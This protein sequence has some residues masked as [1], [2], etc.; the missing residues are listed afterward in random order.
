MAQ[1][2]YHL[3]ADP[4][5]FD[6]THQDQ[7]IVLS[8]ASWA[9]YKRLLEIRGDRPVPRFT[10]LEGV[11]E[12]MNPS[13]THDFT[14]S[15]L[16]R[17]VEAWCFAK[18]IDFTPVGSWTLENEAAERAVEPDECYCLGENASRETPERPD[19]AIEVIHTSGGISKLDVYRKLA[20][21]EVWIWKKGAIAVHVLRGESYEA[22]SGSEQ[23]PGI[24]LD[25]L[26]RFIQ[27]R[28]VSRAVREYRQAL[29]EQG[30]GSP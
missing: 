14:K 2:A 28:P 19:L 8:G 30:E 24:D 3:V 26:L 11:L 20:V 5:G 12:L 18:G 15:S 6:R 16:G 22:V 23:L 27:I 9:D 1:P 17:L 29:G 25:E 10:Y 7:V 13:L 4:L 21:S